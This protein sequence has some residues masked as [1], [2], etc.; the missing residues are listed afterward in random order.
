M[1]GNDEIL[2][3][4]S[5]AARTQLHRVRNEVVAATGRARDASL[6]MRVLLAHNYIERRGRGVRARWVTTMRGDMY[7][8]ETRDILDEKR[9]QLCATLLNFK[10]GPG[11]ERGAAFRALLAFDIEHPEVLK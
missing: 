4:I 10:D 9:R 8:L 5:S 3:S 7:L 6:E 11:E 2:L 1:S